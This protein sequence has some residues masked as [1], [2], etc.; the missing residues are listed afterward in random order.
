VTIGTFDLGPDVLKAVQ[1]G[2]LA[3]AVDQQPYLQGYL[4]VVFLAELA[5]HG[6][7]PA[8]GDVI[9]TG[10]NFVTRANAAKAIEL[11]KRSIR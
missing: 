3:F 7:F 6:L 9:P 10:P 5:R 4:P 1:D 8:Q 2:R 11:A